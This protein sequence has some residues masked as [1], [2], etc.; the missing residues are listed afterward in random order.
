MNRPGHVI[1]YIIYDNGT[2]HEACHL[3]GG[4]YQSNRQDCEVST[5]RQF[6]YE[7][8]NYPGYGPKPVR[9]TVEER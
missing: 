9:Y 7:V 8:R 3:V 5:Q 4:D 2:R 1:G 6:D